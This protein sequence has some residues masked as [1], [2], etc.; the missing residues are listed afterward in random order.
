MADL[1]RSEVSNRQF[2]T[3]AIKLEHLLW[4]STVNIAVCVCI[5]HGLTTGDREVLHDLGFLAM[6]GRSSLGRAVVRILCRQHERLSADGGRTRSHVRLA[7]RAVL[8]RADPHL[9]RRRARRPAITLDLGGR[10]QACGCRSAACSRSSRCCRG[11]CSS[12]RRSGHHR[13]IQRTA[14][15]QLSGSPTPTL[16]LPVSDAVERC[17][18]TSSRRAVA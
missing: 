9:P 2:W 8:F 7:E 17:P 3:G 10:A 4:A 18:M 5:W 15:V 11:C 6:V 16:L 1:C 13:L 12:S 14:D